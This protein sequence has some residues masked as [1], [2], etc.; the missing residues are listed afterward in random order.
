MAKL[1]TVQV[2]T[3]ESCCRKKIKKQKFKLEEEFSLFGAYLAKYMEKLVF[4][5]KWT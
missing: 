1:K 5:N 4:G 2:F 3:T